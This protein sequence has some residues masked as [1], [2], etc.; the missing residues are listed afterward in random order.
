MLYMKLLAIG[1]QKSQ[2]YESNIKPKKIQNQLFLGQ[3]QLFLVAV[4]NK[5]LATMYS[6]Y[7]RDMYKQILSQIML[8]KKHTFQAKKTLPKNINH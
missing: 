2:A 6:Y 5:S 3:K 1:K 7:V 4:Q 8:H